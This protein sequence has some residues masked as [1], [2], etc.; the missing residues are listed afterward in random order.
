MALKVNHINHRLRLV[1][2][3]INSNNET[4]LKAREIAK[5]LQFE[6]MYR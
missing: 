4:I 2:I 1:V 3:N 6:I 5:K